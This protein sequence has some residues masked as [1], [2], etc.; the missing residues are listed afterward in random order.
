M[1]TTF[2][3]VRAGLASVPSLCGFAALA[4]KSVVKRLSK[5]IANFAQDIAENKRPDVFVEI[6]KP[7]TN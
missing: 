2:G 7:L 3:E 4:Q 1:K 5:Y 6:L